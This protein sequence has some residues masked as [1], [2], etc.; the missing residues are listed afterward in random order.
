MCSESH[1][2]CFLI[3]VLKVA[4]Q[5][6]IIA[7]DMRERYSDFGFPGHEF[8]PINRQQS[9]QRNDWKDLKCMMS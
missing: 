9:S 6:V 3:F 5:V 4:L 8:K 2:V 7:G 1:E